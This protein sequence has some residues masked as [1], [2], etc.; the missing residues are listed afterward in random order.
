MHHEISPIWLQEQTFMS[1][2]CCF[3]RIDSVNEYYD[4]GKIVRVVRGWLLHQND[5]ILSL[6][7][8]FNNHIYPATTRIPRVDVE[9]AFKS[10]KHASTAGFT[11]VIDDITLQTFPS[12]IAPSF[13]GVTF[14]STVFTGTMQPYHIEEKASLIFSTLDKADNSDALIISVPLTHNKLLSSYEQLIQKLSNLNLSCKT[15]VTTENKIRQR[16]NWLNYG[17][18]KLTIIFGVSAWEEFIGS[19]DIHILQQ[20][21]TKIIFINDNNEYQFGYHPTVTH[22]DIDE[23]QKISF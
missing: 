14:G 9:Q 1:S 16:Q 3:G 4:N 15:V 23:I 2:G 8:K 20:S 11:F 7:F 6:K 18:Y 5:Q 21:N 13:A 22:F 17:K 10:L 19:P 12:Q